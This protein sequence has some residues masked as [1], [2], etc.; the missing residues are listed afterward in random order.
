MRPTAAWLATSLRTLAAQRVV[1]NEIG[2][3]KF[4]K[5]AFE[6]QFRGK[7]LKLKQLPLQGDLHRSMRQ[8]ASMPKEDQDVAKA[9]LISR[10]S[11]GRYLLPTENTSRRQ[12]NLILQWLGLQR[13]L[14]LAPTA[15]FDWNR[16]PELLDMKR[17]VL[18]A[19]RFDVIR[20]SDLPLEDKY[21]AVVTWLKGTDFGEFVLQTRAFPPN[22]PDYKQALLDYVGKER[23][24]ELV[25]RP[26]LFD[27]NSIKGCTTKFR[28]MLSRIQLADLSPEEEE[29]ALVSLLCTTQLGKRL[30]LE[31]G[32]PLP[33]LFS[34]EHNKVIQSYKPLHGL[35]RDPSSANIPAEIQ[36]CVDRIG[37]DRFLEL[38]HEEPYDLASI[39]GFETVKTT[40]ARLRLVQESKL[41]EEEKVRAFA[42]VL[43]RSAWAELLAGD[44]MEARRKIRRTQSGRA[45]V[46][47]G[48]YGFQRR[49]NYLGPA[50]FLELSREPI[51]DVVK[52]FPNLDP[53][54]WPSFWTAVYHSDLEGEERERWFASVLR[55]SSHGKRY[56]A[57]VRRIAKEKGDPENLQPLSDPVTTAIWRPRVTKESSPTPSVSLSRS[58]EPSIA[59]TSAA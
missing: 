17:T 50:R 11:L 10:R 24:L 8:I 55:R 48:P 46:T 35:Y 1:L 38:V 25:A 39:K 45:S 18:P 36:A 15:S 28:H 32:L 41:T 51:I 29:R 19:A 9:W 40:K 4:R 20:E 44:D 33:D 2:E 22:P 23:F 16:L 37:H 47:K 53:A 21:L 5:L 26:P 30:I 27:L 12:F 52:A 59:Q 3:D 14:N 43:C 58:P 54:E 57:E 6:L 31:A 13:F 56:L 7:H 34:Y 42:A 49:L